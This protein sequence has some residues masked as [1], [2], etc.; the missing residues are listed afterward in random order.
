MGLRVA[1]FLLFVLI[2]PQCFAGT[3][4]DFEGSLWNGTT[5]NSDTFG[6]YTTN[7]DA[8]SFTLETST[9]KIGDGAMRVSTDEENLHAWI[10]SY[11]SSVE[12]RLFFEEFTLAHDRM[13][14]YMLIPSNYPLATGTGT[15]I[16]NNNDHNFNLGTFSNTSVTNNTPAISIQSTGISSMMGCTIE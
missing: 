12:T 5:N 14:F 16:G 11:V 13:S 4:F 6:C 15:V 3:F 10:F 9:V 1:Y 2:S 7:P 8:N